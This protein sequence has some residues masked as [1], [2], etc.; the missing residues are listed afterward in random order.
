LI[1]I[2]HR[3]LP[4]YL[5]RAERAEKERDAM[6]EQFIAAR[7]AAVNAEQDAIAAED[8][9]ANLREELTAARKSIGKT[10]GAHYG[11]KH[12]GESNEYS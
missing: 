4:Q 1:D 6:L 12:G 10:T 5:G 7:S 3:L 9:L 8:K 11:Q 2:K